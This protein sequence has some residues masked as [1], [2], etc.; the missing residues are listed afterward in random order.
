[1]VGVS[2]F[3]FE[4]AAAQLGLSPA[5][6]K[7]HIKRLPHTR[8]GHLVRFTPEQVAEIRSMHERRPDAAAVEASALRPTTKRRAS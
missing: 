4:T 7:K 2:D 8:Y 5:W 6:L 3:D 1:V